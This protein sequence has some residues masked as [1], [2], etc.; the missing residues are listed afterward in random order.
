M[1]SH[2][3]SV[4][5]ARSVMSSRL[6]IGVAT[7]E[8][9]PIQ[10]IGNLLR[11]FINISCPHGDD[12]RVVPFREK[13]V[14]DLVEGVECD[15]ST[16]V[17]LCRAREDVVGDGRVGCFARGIN[18]GNERPVR[19]RERG[20]KSLQET[21]RT[22]KEVRVERD[23]YLFVGKFL[24]RRADGRTDGGRVVRIVIVD[25]RA[26]WCLALVLEAAPR[27]AERRECLVGA[28]GRN[29]GERDPGGSFGGPRVHAIEFTDEMQTRDRLLRII[30]DTRRNV[31]KDRQDVRVVRMRDDGSV[32]RNV[33]RR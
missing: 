9:F 23:N 25:K 26:A 21:S 10:L 1:T 28:F 20:G 16:A 32:R 31:C 5:R 3:L 6:P 2:S 24:P 8:S 7:I 17:L 27:A 19:T 33:L 30:D 22:A 12:E 15:D 13:S 4:R 29:V 18:G 11:Y 14:A